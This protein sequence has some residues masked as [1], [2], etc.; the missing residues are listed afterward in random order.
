MDKVFISLGFGCQVAENLNE[1]KLRNFSLPFDWTVPHSG[2]DNIIKT[3][4]KNYIPKDKFTNSNGDTHAVSLIDHTIFPH[5]KFPEDNEKMQRRINR[6]LDL[7]KEEKKELIFIKRSH[8]DNH[9]VAEYAE[10]YNWT[11]KNDIDECEE[12]HSFLKKTYP[13]LKFKIILFLLCS[14]CFDSNC[15]SKNIEIY[16]VSEPNCD[17]Q[18]KDAMAQAKIKEVLQKEIAPPP[19]Y[20]NIYIHRPQSITF[21]P[22]DPT[23][24]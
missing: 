4:F 13:K 15:R 10:K 9:H 6:F 8:M 23:N 18:K 22:F 3:N 21:N 24:A 7:L 2:V 12:I 14:K 5:N 19:Q 1:L 11:V 16:H 20:N 17:F